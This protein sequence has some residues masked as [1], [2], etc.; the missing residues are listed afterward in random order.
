MIEG[1]NLA[2][3]LKRGNSELDGCLKIHRGEKNKKK[4]ENADFWKELR[5]F[6]EKLEN[7]KVVESLDKPI[8]TEIP[9][10]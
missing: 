4:K 10:I 8:I 7:V 9:H 5:K 6:Q 2:Y 1:S 3:R